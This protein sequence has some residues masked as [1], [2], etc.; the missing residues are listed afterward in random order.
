MRK[1]RLFYFA[2]PLIRPGIGPRY[3]HKKG[4]GEDPTP[5]LLFILKAGLIL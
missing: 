5:I 3:R 4:G 2:T 1:F